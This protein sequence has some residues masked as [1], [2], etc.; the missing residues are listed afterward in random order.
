MRLSFGNNVIN[1]SVDNRFI[2]FHIFINIVRLSAVVSSDIFSSS[3]LEITVLTTSANEDIIASVIS[4]AAS[5]GLVELPSDMAVTGLL[6]IPLGIALSVC[7]SAAFLPSVRLE[8]T[9]RPSFNND[10]GGTFVL[11]EP[12]SNGGL[13]VEEPFL[14]ALVQLRK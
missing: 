10:N 6:V 11:I 12:G 9:V 7:V 14:L 4:A 2:I 5:I 8:I 13:V 1:R 3:G